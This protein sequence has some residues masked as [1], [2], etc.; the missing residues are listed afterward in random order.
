MEREHLIIVAI[1]ALVLF[2]LMKHSDDCNCSGYMKDKMVN[3]PAHIRYRGD[4]P[5]STAA[6]IRTRRFGGCG[7]DGTSDCGSLG[8]IRVRYSDKYIGAGQHIKNHIRHDSRQSM[9]NGMFSG[10]PQH[11]RYNEELTAAA[12]P[13]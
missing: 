10:S 11:I 13:P 8:H 1:L 12:G 4:E 7:P 2:M 5:T 6:H 9:F 3:M